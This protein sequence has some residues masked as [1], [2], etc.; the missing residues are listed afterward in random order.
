MEIKPNIFSCGVQDP[1]LRIFDII[2]CT[3]YGTSYN[4]FIVKGEEKTALIEVVKAH[5]WDEYLKNANAITPV[6]KADYLIVNHTEPDHAGSIASLLRVNPD[7]TVVG[8][9]SA[10]MFLNKI[11]NMPFKSMTVKAG[12]SLDLGGKKLT[13]HPM[14]NLHWPD[15]MFTFEET[16]RTLFSCDFLG[17]HYSYP[18]LLLSAMKERTSYQKAQRQYFLDIMGPFIN[19]FVIN[20]TKKARELN[21]S[22]IC[23]GHGPVLDV[24]IAEAFDQYDAWCQQDK[25]EKPFVALAYVSSY[26]YTRELAE[27]IKATLE[28]LGTIE[29]KAF[30]V[31]GDNHQDAVN[32][33]LQSDGFLL[34]TPTIVG[35]AL[36]PIME[37][38]LSVLPPL[39]KGKVASAFGSYG[40]SGEG[41][42]NVMARLGQLR[43]KT[44]EGYKV[45]FKPN[46]EELE[47]ARQFAI[48]FAQE[49][50]KGK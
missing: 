26:G 3:P 44:I 45:R 18:P 34:G 42:P 38:L 41:V 23:T 7:I 36:R 50:T 25:N 15:T 8:T 27:T 31:D 32:A 10:I 20:G 5:F 12:D 43:V 17:A 14:P 37:L 21:P 29:V 33:I 16:T 47:G 49:V 24:D 22:I 1:E 30:E 13:F 28:E 9:S 48:Q 11:V 39:V 6:E 19:P 46:E 4:A 35:D 40:W 2:M